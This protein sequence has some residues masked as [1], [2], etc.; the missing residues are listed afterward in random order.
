MVSS[1]G[2]HYR[3]K[4]LLLRLLLILLARGL[5]VRPFGLAPGKF[6][7]ELETV[8]ARGADAVSDRRA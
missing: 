5:R 7:S 2:S 1:P 8:D 3:R 6:S 4:Y